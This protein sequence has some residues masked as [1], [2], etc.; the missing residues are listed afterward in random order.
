MLK[1]PNCRSYLAAHPEAKEEW[2]SETELNQL[3]E[4]LPEAP[5]VASNFT[6]LVLQ[7][8]E[9][10]A[11][12]QPRAMGWPAW[13]RRVRRW[14]PKAA[15]A[16]LTIGLGVFAYEQ[17]QLKTRAAMARN[18]AE[19]TEMVSASNPELLEDFEPIRRLSDPEPKADVGIACLILRRC[20]CSAAIFCCCLPWAPAYGFL[21]RFTPRLPPPLR[22]IIRLCSGQS[23][24]TAAAAA[25]SKIAG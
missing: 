7:A 16:C 4:Q 10:E 11:A 19:L 13:L 24:P 22:S 23:R 1:R 9:R 18:V 6:A 2:E 3:L 20:R 5:P 21:S 14:L 12:A 8:V 15:M 25:H 17:H